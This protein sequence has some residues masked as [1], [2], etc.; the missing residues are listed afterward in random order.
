MASQTRFHDS[1]YRL[2]QIG[3]PNGIRLMRILE[4]HQDNR[5]RAQ[6]V[7][8]DDGSPQLVD[9]DTTIVTNLAE[10][11]DCPGQVPADT[12]AV[13]LD[14]E[15]RWVVFLR[16]PAAAAF[17]V[18]ILSSEGGAEYM[19]RPQVVQP[20]GEFADESGASDVVA[21]NLAE[22]SLGPGAAVDVGTKVLVSS[23][24]DTG[25]PP[26]IRYFFDHPAYAKYLD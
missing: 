4:L 8:F 13:A 19:A 16:R 26:T 15:G 23:L 14:V 17:V 6:A 9:T 22:L 18:R 25:S 7:E 24:P 20:S 12:D 11:A 10:P 5:Y 3:S 21:T 2:A 1:L